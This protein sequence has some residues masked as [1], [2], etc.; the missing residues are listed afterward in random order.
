M[1]R[2]AVISGIGVI[3][4]TIGAAL[5]PAAAAGSGTVLPADTDTLYTTARS[6]HSVVLHWST[7][8]V[9]DP[10]DGAHPTKWLVTYQAGTTAPGPNAKHHFVVQDR[11]LKPHVIAGLK[12]GK[13]YTAT[14]YGEKGGTRSVPVSLTF[15]ARVAGAHVDTMAKHELATV[16]PR[17]KN[18]TD[19][20]VA[21]SSTGRRFA[22]FSTSHTVWFSQA[23]ATGQWSKPVHLATNKIGDIGPVRISRSKA[24]LA[25]A[26]GNFG[27]PKYR[28][29][30]AG[31]SHWAATKP[32]HASDIIQGFALDNNAKLHLIAGG[33]QHAAYV[34]NASGKW[35]STKI[36]DAHGVIQ[37]HAMA[38]TI[39][40]A[41][42][43]VIVGAAPYA[44][45]QQDGSVTLVTE[46]AA[47]SS[48]ATSVSNWHVINSM[49]LTAD[50]ANGVAGVSV[51]GDNGA[52]LV[53]VSLFPLTYDRRATTTDASG[54][55]L[56]SGTSPDNVAH[57]SRVAGS[58]AVEDTAL[59]SLASTSKGYLYFASHTSPWRAS[60][61]G[62]DRSTVSLNTSGAWSASKL[63]QQSTLAY[64]VVRYIGTGKHGDIILS[65]LRQ[66]R[67]TEGAE[68]ITV[69]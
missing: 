23:S 12:R 43:R 22:V 66:A 7:E 41:T 38:L 39:D 45:R 13:P 14:I 33:P 63:Y 2:L 37:P 15:A 31:S 51:A 21:S 32:L 25:A 59:V 16:V 68:D 27:D 5:T 58:D 17:S 44:D 64:D 48:T 54:M 60:K 30:K 24:G 57:F 6:A 46:D 52:T 35:T 36:K 28:L 34:T 62:T 53:G 9:D 4:M 11:N 42:Q 26:W 56:A 29:L 61:L 67:S 69:S 50:E 3:A 47:I 8:I 18:A 55:Y 1:T 40:P 19:V 10:S 65:Y 49:P 20:A